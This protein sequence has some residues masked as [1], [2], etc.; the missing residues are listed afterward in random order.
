[1]SYPHVRVSAG[2][3]SSK[4]GRFFHPRTAARIYPDHADYAGTAESM[5]WQRFIST[6]WVR[7]QGLEPER[8]H[9]AEDVVL[10][11]GGWTRRRADDSPIVSNRVLYTLTRLD[12]GWGIQARFGVDSF[13]PDGNQQALAEPATQS[14]A[15]RR[16]A[17]QAGDME[18]WLNCFHFPLTAV[19]APGCVQ[20]LA[21]PDQLRAQ[22]QIWE[23][24]AQSKGVQVIAAGTTGALLALKPEGRSGAGR[25]AALVARREG[26]WKTLAI[27]LLA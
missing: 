14:A 5:G 26:S 11:A 18:R 22:T 3:P 7:T 21:D 8:V 20:V 9:A 25:G 23:S 4:R 13:D 1:M 12:G 10:L 16:A 2:P 15:L 19:V 27:T 24:E 6:G 17:R